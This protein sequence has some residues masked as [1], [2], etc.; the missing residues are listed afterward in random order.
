[1]KR[2][3]WEVEIVCACGCGESFTEDKRVGRPRTFLDRRHSRRQA[4]R[5][6]RERQAK[7]AWS[8]HNDIC[9]RPRPRSVQD[10]EKA[11]DRH[12]DYAQPGKL[13]C[14]LA[15]SR[16]SMRCPVA[17]YKDFYGDKR[18]C[19]VYATLFDDMMSLKVSGWQRRNTHE[20][21]TWK[22]DAERADALSPQAVEPNKPWEDPEVYA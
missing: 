5:N 4:Q 10:G 7:G 8:T 21:G 12:C 15:L 1:M 2:Q 19:I 14:S 18:M 16:T 3:P 9:R 13:N 6:Y 22:T 20:D 17:F 11:L